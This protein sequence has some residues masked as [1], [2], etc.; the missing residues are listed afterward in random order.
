MSLNTRSC[1]RNWADN[2][3]INVTLI[4]SPFKMSQAI[5]KRIDLELKNSLI[6][7]FPYRCLRSLLCSSY[8]QD[9]M[10]STSAP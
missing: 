10:F 5:A 7:R 2:Y 8:S 6:G 3:D 9:K 1:R 4:M